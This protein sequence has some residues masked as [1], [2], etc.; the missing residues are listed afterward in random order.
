MNVKIRRKILSR[1]MIDSYVSR[2]GKKFFVESIKNK[3]HNATAEFQ[4]PMNTTSHGEDV[5]LALQQ[6]ELTATLFSR[7]LLPFSVHMT[8]PFR[9]HRYV[10]H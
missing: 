7:A 4:L 5:E 8:S 6:R 3:I 9:T 10:T 1:Q 2:K